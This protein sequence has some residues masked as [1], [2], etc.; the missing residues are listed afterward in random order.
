MKL[1]ILASAWQ[2]GNELADE[3]DLFLSRMHTQRVLIV[4]VSTH[5][6][7]WPLKYVVYQKLN[8]KDTFIWY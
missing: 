8:K 7:T 5:S 4:C 6:L 1:L 3:R 2:F